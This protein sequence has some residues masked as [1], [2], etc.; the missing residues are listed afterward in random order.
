MSQINQIKYTSILPTKS[1]TILKKRNLDLTVGG[2]KNYTNLIKNG[3]QIEWFLFQVDYV[4]PSQNVVHLK[5]L[6]R[7]D[8]TRLR[9]ALRGSSGDAEKR[10]KGRKPVQKLFDVDA[11]RAV[12]GEVTSDGDFLIF[13]GNRYSRKGFL[14]KSFA[15]SAIVAEGIKPTLSELERFEDQPEGIDIEGKYSTSYLML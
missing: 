6:P 11:I 5:L 13:E 7:V 1:N 15:M 2:D 9:G 3:K 4:E 10:K 8:Y 14:Y 12:G